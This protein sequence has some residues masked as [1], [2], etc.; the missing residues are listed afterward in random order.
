MPPGL[1]KETLDNM[2]D[3]DLSFAARDS[4]EAFSF[5]LPGDEGVMDPDSSRDCLP[6]DFP[7]VRSVCSNEERS[8]LKVVGGLL[9]TGGEGSMCEADGWSRDAEAAIARD[10]DA[11]GLIEGAM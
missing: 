10:V 3:L 1:R 5:P 8:R 6:L 9:S 11:S 4:S 7:V 2:L